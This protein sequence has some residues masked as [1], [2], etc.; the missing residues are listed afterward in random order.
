MAILRILLLMVSVALAGIKPTA[1][2]SLS[3]DLVTQP[4]FRADMFSVDTA[5]RYGGNWFGLRV[6][7]ANGIAYEQLPGML[8]LRFSAHLDSTI[9][10]QSVLPIRRDLEAWYRDPQ[11]GSIFSTPNQVDINL[12]KEGWF[13]WNNALGFLKCGRFKPD[14]GPSPNS[15]VLGSAPPSQDAIWWHFDLGMPYFDWYIS[16]LDPILMGT[17]SANT[18]VAPE[19]SETWNQSHLT[20]SNQRN[21]IYDEPSKMLALH[22]LGWDANWGWFALIEQALIGGKTPTPRDFNPWIV[23]HD[24]FSDGYTKSSTTAELGLK[25]GKHSKFYWQVDFEDIAS[26]VGEEGGQTAPTTLGSLVGWRQDWRTDSVLSL[27]SR[28]DAVYTDPSFNNHRLPLQ[29]MTVR[30]L[31]RS[32]YREQADPYFVDSYV[33]DYPLGYKRG[34]DAVDLWLNIGIKSK[35]YHCGGEAE[36]AWL[37]Q[38]DKELW[39]PWDTAAQF[40]SALSGVV[41]HEKRGSI[42]GWYTLYPHTDRNPWSMGLSSG[43]GLRQIRNEN[44]IEDNNRWDLVWSAGLTGSYAP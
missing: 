43:F 29:K 17:P 23:W 20:V 4:G 14:M 24:N 35:K 40:T 39:T 12:P 22:R 2:W 36:F 32:N 19:G 33:V 44:H 41:E 42:S 31:Y 15:V 9:E 21:R 1:N 27:W 8:T 6:P 5:D 28:L 7:L 38:G 30:R 34:P 3:T 18:G 10:I 25:P 11:G 16:S 37:R 26:P 13:Q